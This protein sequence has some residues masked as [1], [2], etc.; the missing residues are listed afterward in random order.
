MMAFAIF[1]AVGTAVALVAHQLRKSRALFAGTPG[2]PLPSLV[3]AIG[4]AMFGGYI[5]IITQVLRSSEPATFVLAVVGSIAFLGAYHMLVRH[6]HAP[7][8]GHG[9]AR[10]ARGSQAN[11]APPAGGGAHTL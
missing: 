3:V 2:G 9:R 11:I 5:G 6:H 10:R 1:L 8:E 7:R 4:G